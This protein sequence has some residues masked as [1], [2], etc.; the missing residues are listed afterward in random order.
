[1]FKILNSES[2]STTGAALLIGGA[3]LLNKIIGVLRDRIIAHY[4]GAGP[5]TDAYYAAFKIPDL[6]YNL[7]IVGA[8]TA[9]FIPVFTKL[10]LEGKDKSTAWK[11]ANNVLNLAAVTLVVLCGLGIIFAPLLVP[12]L[13]PGFTSENLNLTTNLTRVMF[14]S[15]IFL[16]FSMVLGGVLQSLRRF[17][18][19]S[20][21]PIFYNLG[22]I[23]GAV[24]LTKFVGPIGLAIG[25]AIGAFIHFALQYYGAHLVGYRW[26]PIF[27]L[28]EKNTRLIG[29][30]M[31]PRTLGLAVSNVNTFVTTI[32]ASLLPAGSVAVYNY[33][34]NLQ[35]VPIGVI[36]ISFALATFPMLSASVAEG[37]KE[38][39]VASL[40]STM[41]Q[42]LFLII[43]VSLI[44][45][46]LRAQIVRVVLGSGAFDWNAT[47]NTADALAFFAL[48]LFA[49]SLIPLFARAF[50]A[51]SNTK[52][53]FIIGVIA[54]LVN[55]IASLVLMEPLGVAGLAL[56]ASIGAIIN[57][58]LLLVYLKTTLHDLEENKLLSSLYR[59][60]VAAIA[61]GLVMQY[62]KTPLAAIFNQDYFWGIFGQGLIAGISGLSIY[63]LLCYILRLPEMMNLAQGFHKKW[64]KIK[65]IKTD[66]EG[67][68][69][70]EL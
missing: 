60:S 33:A 46:I 39:F 51:L 12:L 29:R 34:D 68:N 14:L 27:K 17:V 13:A 37:N 49:Q 65:N 6:V 31:I 23:F 9:G 1:M 24:G 57:F 26:S 11:L 36:G 3:T 30:L 38:K 4:Y 61:M 67:I 69:L 18:L 55:I 2:N 45:L 64:L 63:L 16:G 20:F 10:F 58:S 48:G 50:Y 32:L 70:K 19:Y 41:R 28:R 43:P 7:L 25:V 54:A 35:W 52:T 59:I 47:V 40:G 62:I 44:L 15:P 8:L 53:P 42:I 22:I 5:V 21:A 56:A 66:Q